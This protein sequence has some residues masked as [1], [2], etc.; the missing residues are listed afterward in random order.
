MV[1]PRKTKDQKKHR[2]S[3]TIDKSI[4]D[5]LQKRKI[6]ISTYTN[7]LLRIALMGDTDPVA[8][9]AYGSK[10]TSAILAGGFIFYFCAVSQKIL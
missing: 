6:K 10:V 7:Q 3:L 8:N 1:R 4:Y 2:I 9:M 5:N